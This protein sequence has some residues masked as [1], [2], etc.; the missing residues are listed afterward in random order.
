MSRHRPGKYPGLPRPLL[1]AA[2]TSSDSEEDVPEVAPVPAAAPTPGNPAPE[3]EPE[4]D[5]ILE[6]T[7]E[8]PNMP[9]TY[10][11]MTYDIVTGTSID[12]DYRKILCSHCMNSGFY[13][14][15]GRVQINDGDKNILVGP[16]AGGD[17][18]V[19]LIQPGN[20]G[21]FR[22]ENRVGMSDEVVEL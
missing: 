14:L 20:P 2:T 11:A 15:S 17:P 6:D 10:R 12:E 8:E 22:P 4:A 18:R 13:R 21:Q 16:E 5:P 3:E 1:D 9:P 19:E 7:E